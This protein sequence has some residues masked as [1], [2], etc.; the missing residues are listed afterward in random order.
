MRRAL[1][2]EANKAYTCGDFLIATFDY[3]PPPQ[4]QAQ[5]VIGF[6][7][8]DVFRVLLD[9]EAVEGGV[10]WVY[11]ET[12]SGQVRG[13]IPPKFVQH[14]TVH[15]T[16]APNS[17]AVLLG[18]AP[19]S[20]HSDPEHLRQAIAR[21]EAQ[22]QLEAKLEAELEHAK[23]INTLIAKEF[24]ALQTHAM[25]ER[26]LAL[27]AE[28]VA[29]DLEQAAREQAHARAEQELAARKARAE[30]DLELHEARAAQT[31]ADREERIA[32]HQ[33]ELE[34]AERE[35]AIKQR[36]LNIEREAHEQA[37]ED[38][39]EMEREAEE[40]QREVLEQKFRK[41]SVQWD[42]MG[43]VNVLP[44][45][46]SV[47]ERRFQWR[48]GVQETRYGGRHVEPWPLEA[49]LEHERAKAAANARSR[50]GRQVHRSPAPA[51]TRSRPE[52]Q[53]H[54]SPARA[55]PSYGRGQR[56]RAARRSGAPVA[57]AAL[58]TGASYGQSPLAAALQQ[59]RVRAS[60]S[61]QRTSTL[62]RAN[63]RVGPQ[64]DPTRAA[65]FAQQSSGTKGPATPGQH[66][67]RTC[68]TSLSADDEA[69]RICATPS[70]PSTAPLSDMPALSAPA[71]APRAARNATKRSV[72]RIAP[73]PVGFRPR[74]QGVVDDPN[75]A[76][77]PGF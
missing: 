44:S 9:S 25:K 27:T 50:R 52:R 1:L 3:A 36:L 18:V 76:P 75:N 66:N 48:D 73:P 38:R 57:P 62:R 19:R 72:I 28:K 49:K 26:E 71:A 63:S 34:R 16:S 17:P 56:D 41:E 2:S 60:N 37:E 5:G 77:P 51:Y 10:S 58:P 15:Q 69:C 55:M 30:R 43:H 29:F 12:D 31:L 65:A 22:E 14:R 39:R 70:L 54:Q 33:L 13:Y 6:A 61:M 59:E 46:R 64:T 40:R 42:W 21:A 24:I 32:A 67:C 35:V 47:R 11:A 7:R 8:G 45:A 68:G 23:T 20:I 4:A 74:P 53:A